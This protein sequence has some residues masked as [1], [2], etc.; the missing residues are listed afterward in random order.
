MKVWCEMAI[1]SFQL[2]ADG[3]GRQRVRYSGSCGLVKIS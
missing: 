1:R 2:L 3:F